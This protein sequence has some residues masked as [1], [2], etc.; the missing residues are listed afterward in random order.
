MIRLVINKQRLEEAGFFLN[1]HA[2]KGEV[3]HL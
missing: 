1:V 2:G 3:P